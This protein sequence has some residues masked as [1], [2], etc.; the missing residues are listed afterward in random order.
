MKNGNKIPI[1]RKGK[2]GVLYNLRK[3][4]GLSQA[5]IAQKIGCDLK[6]YRNWETYGETIR[7]DYL[8]AL[9]DFF[10]VSTDFLLHR[11]DYISVGDK[12]I[13]DI[14]GL[15]RVS[16]QVLRYLNLQPKN[17]IDEEANSNH[18]TIDLINRVLEHT[19]QHMR[20]SDEGIPYPVF[21]LFSMLEEYIRADSIQ[22][23][24]PFF[25]FENGS[26]P[27]VVDVRKLYAEVK[28]RE[29]QTCINSYRKHEKEKKH[30]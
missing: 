9:A 12:E 19:S 24:K 15:S 7:T 2:N 28:F 4:S 29:I 5:E 10:H 23:E 26:V 3:K 17:E 27:E 21:T 1:S 14:T 22:S 18:D 16:I 8:S 13:S 30:G 6:S 25:T 20:Y 11:I